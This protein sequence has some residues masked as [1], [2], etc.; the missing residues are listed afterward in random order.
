MGYVSFTL[1]ESAMH[2]NGGADCVPFGAHTPLVPSAPPLSLEKRCSECKRKASRLS[3][4]L[5]YGTVENAASHVRVY[6]SFLADRAMET[7]KKF[8][9]R[10]EMEIGKAKATDE[11]VQVG[12]GEELVEKTHANKEDDVFSSYA[13]SSDEDCMY[14]FLAMAEKFQVT[15]LEVMK[16]AHLMQARQLPT[17]HEKTLRFIEN[18]AKAVIW[19]EYGVTPQETFLGLRRIGVIEPVA[20]AMLVQ[21]NTEK[22]K[23]LLDLLVG[24]K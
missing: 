19:K 15:T 12:I 2:L 22:M 3:I 7:L 21:W 17:K 18:S 6:D 5:E 13:P 4:T 10:S 11:N 23:S 20:G 9:N 24:L 16:R 1:A 14:R 8:L